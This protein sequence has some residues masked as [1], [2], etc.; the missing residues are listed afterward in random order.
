V[1]RSVRAC[2]RASVVLRHACTN[3]AVVALDPAAAALDAAL[4][5]REG[6]FGSAGRDQAADMTRPAMHRLVY[7][8][9][10]V[11]TD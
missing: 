6:Q 4:V 5:Q 9:R 2:Y 7:T 10:G 1:L 11:R 8:A 3:A